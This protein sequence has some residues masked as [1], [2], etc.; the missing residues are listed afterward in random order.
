M[1]N[2]N[3]KKNLEH[4]RERYINKIHWYMDNIND[5]NK[6]SYEGAIDALSTAVHD[7]EDI[8]YGLD[9]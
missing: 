6:N 5:S 3:Y 9:V 4:L 2:Y 7:I 8:L 1:D